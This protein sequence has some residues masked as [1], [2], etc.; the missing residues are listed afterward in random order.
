MNTEKEFDKKFALHAAFWYLISEFIF[1]KI[2]NIK[3][4]TNSKKKKL[5]YV[6]LILSTKSTIS[7]AVLKC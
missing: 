3:N 7:C 1:G 2:L 6:S 4:T 5:N